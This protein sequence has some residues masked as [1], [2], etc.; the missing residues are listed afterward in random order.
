MITKQVKKDQARERELRKGE[1]RG[2]GGLQ[3]IQSQLVTNEDSR[4]WLQRTARLL[5]IEACIRRG[6]NIAIERSNECKKERSKMTYGFDQASSPLLFPSRALPRL[7]F[8]S[9]SLTPVGSQAPP[10]LGSRDPSV[11]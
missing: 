5:S 9:R 11:G 10:R 2:E 1:G 8:G 6:Q 7:A 3:R 4:V